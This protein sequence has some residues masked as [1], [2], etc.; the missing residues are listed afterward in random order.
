MSLTCSLS[1]LQAP[2]LGSCSS[3][4]ARQGCTACGPVQ[5]TATVLPPEPSAR[6]LLHHL[7]RRYLT[8]KHGLW[9]DD[10]CQYLGGGGHWV[11]G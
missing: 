11:G 9:L 6:Q 2:T 10:C 7:D 8:Q 1:W 3:S 5:E 4:N